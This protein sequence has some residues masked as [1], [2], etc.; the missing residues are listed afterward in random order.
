MSLSQGQKPFLI[1]EVAPRLATRRVPS[2]GSSPEKA[3]AADRDPAVTEVSWPP[4]VLGGQAASCPVRRPATPPASPPAGPMV[5][6]R[7]PGCVLGRAGNQGP[8]AP[9]YVCLPDSPNSFFLRARSAGWAGQR[10]EPALET[11]SP[12]CRPWSGDQQPGLPS[13][14]HA[15]PGAE[16]AAR[17]GCCPRGPLLPR[18]GRENPLT[19]R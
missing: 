15:W 8:H 10:C 17:A 13:L 11:R 6:P 14:C 5:T 7:G 4:G 12:R 16:P 19:G 1:P 3:A 2:P 9:Q 18:R